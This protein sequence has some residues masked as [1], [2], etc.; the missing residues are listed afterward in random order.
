MAID[1]IYD[2]VLAYADAGAAA[3]VKADLEA[4]VAIAT[5]LDDGLIA[6]MV[7]VGAQFSDGLMPRAFARQSRDAWEEACGH[8]LADR[9]RNIH[10]SPIAQVSPTALADDAARDINAII[11]AAD[12]KLAA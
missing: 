5:I 7:E 11:T 4:G 8:D 3:L 12:S 10:Q 2:A 1:D 9:T 6:V